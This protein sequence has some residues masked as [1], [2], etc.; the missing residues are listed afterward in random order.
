MGAVGGVD[1]RDTRRRKTAMPPTEKME[2]NGCPG[3]DR[4]GTGEEDD[5]QPNC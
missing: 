2:I 4:V 1:V 5:G 3:T